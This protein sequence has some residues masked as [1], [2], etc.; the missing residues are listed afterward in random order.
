MSPSLTE[1]Y[2]IFKLE[3]G[4]MER[5]AHENNDNTMDMASYAEFQRQFKGLR[6]AHKAVLFA[7]RAFWQSLVR[8]DVGYVTLV[9]H[10]KKV[11]RLQLV[12]SSMSCLPFGHI[13]LLV[14]TT[15]DLV[16]ERLAV[17]CHQ[18]VSM[19]HTI[20]SDAA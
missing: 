12:V 3:H 11:E 5:I 4:E 2:Q 18:T 8:H 1:Q 14:L 7:F 10:F 6:E 9:D 20:A 13:C 15:S 17:N 16:C 19:Q